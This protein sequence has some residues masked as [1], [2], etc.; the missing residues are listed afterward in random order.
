[1]KNPGLIIRSSDLHSVHSQLAGFMIANEARIDAFYS[2]ESP[3]S[4]L[5]QVFFFMRLHRG[6]FFLSFLNRVMKCAPVLIIPLVLSNLIDT[7]TRGASPEEWIP[8]LTLNL[9]MALLSLGFNILAAWLDGIIFRNLVRIFEAELRSAMIRKLQRLPVSYHKKQQTGILTNKIIVDI[10]R[11]GNI[12]SSY[13]GDMFQVFTYIMV[14]VIVSLLSSPWMTL[15]CLLSI[16]VTFLSISFF[17]RFSGTK[18]HDYRVNLEQSSAAIG[19]MLTNITLT[20]VH[21]LDRI[22]VL[23]ARGIAEEGSFEE[24]MEKQG[25]FCSMYRQSLDK[26][27]PQADGAAT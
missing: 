12:Y 4:P 24:L 9:L 5:K 13:I 21:G 2:A 16:P 11:A 26:N 19:E 20:R 1:M 25:L 15:F 14:T 17:H 6:R 23:N 10:E 3:P 7:V 8:V 22:V 27:V 18:N